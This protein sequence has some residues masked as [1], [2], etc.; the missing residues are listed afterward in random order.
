MVECDEQPERQGLLGSL[1]K[2]GDGQRSAPHLG[3]DTVIDQ[4]SLVRRNDHSC[5]VGSIMSSRAGLEL[6]KFST[7]TVVVEPL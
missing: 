7:Q 6:R 5:S 2:S 4:R 1:E 3:Q